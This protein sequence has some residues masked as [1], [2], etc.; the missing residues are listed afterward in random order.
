MSSSDDVASDIHNVEAFLLQAK[1]Y[2]QDPRASAA[3]FS[4]YKRSAASA[5]RDSILSSEILRC[6]FSTLEQDLSSLET[7][8]LAYRDS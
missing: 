1:T 5:V 7:T 2:L 6:Q 8:L 4:V 3:H